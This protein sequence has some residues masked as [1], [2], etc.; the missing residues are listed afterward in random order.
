MGI[1]GNTDGKGCNNNAAFSRDNLSPVAT[2]FTKG[3][4]AEAVKITLNAKGSVVKVSDGSRK[5]EKEG[6]RL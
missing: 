1:E 2:R 5:R 4:Y 3:M 6:E